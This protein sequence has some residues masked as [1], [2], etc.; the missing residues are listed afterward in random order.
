MAVILIGT[1][2]PQV[3]FSSCIIKIPSRPLKLHPNLAEYIGNFVFAEGQTLDSVQPLAVSKAGGSFDS[4]E[5]YV[6]QIQPEVECQIWLVYVE[7][8]DV[9]DR[10]FGV[11]LSKNIKRCFLSVGFARE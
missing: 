1:N 11:L 8:S 4:F 2:S 7:I 10:K 3:S 9:L 6:E 5:K